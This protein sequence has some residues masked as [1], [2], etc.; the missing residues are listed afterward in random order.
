MSLRNELRAQTR[1][2]TP[3][4]L[5]Q[6]GMMAMGTVDAVMVGRIPGEDAAEIA[7]AAVSLGNMML[8]AG[9]SFAMGVLFGLDPVL[10][11]ALG[12]R[13]PKQFARG[14]QRGFLVGAAL[15]VL[16]AIPL[17]LARPLLSMLDQPVDVVPDASRYAQITVAGLP[18]FLGFT[19]L[20]QT[21]IALGRMRAVIVAVI[22][23][24]G[25]NVLANWALIFG[26]L[27]LPAMG[28][29][30]S[31]W[32][33]TLSRYAMFLGVL[34]LAWP[35]ISERALPL[36][37][38]SLARK[39]I[40][41]F[42]R[43]GLPVGA[44][45]ALEYGAF[46]MVAVM[47]GWIGAREQAGHLVA[48]NLAALSFMVPVGVSSAGTVRVGRAIGAGDHGG[49]RHASW[50]ALLLGVGFMATAAIL[51]VSLPETLTALY[52]PDLDVVQVASALLVIAAA[53]QLFDG[54]QVVTLGLLRGL[55]DTTW[56]AVVN[57]FGYW[58]VGCPLG[59][60]LAFRAGLGA[61]G[62]WWGLVAGLGTVAVI[63]AVRLS[64]LLAS[65]VE[66]VRIES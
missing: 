56:P 52:T 8:F 50:A 28:V 64:R 3:V 43:L 34:Y 10:S 48:L 13:D 32:A 24:N 65:G 4:V 15:T 51:F 53:F 63:L 66:R 60:W 12:A 37:R 7:L 6:L 23:A 11:Q 22:L 42:L 25:V 45:Q 17:L 39:P 55:G 19:V 36:D 41:R 5:A 49:A 33:S 1:L 30:G 21:S 62:L 16:V 26:H 57:L 58:C 38:E 35:E 59:W 47:M 44:Q 31:A 54:T 40:L 20:R 61:S 18:A 9:G 46:A 29:A 2:A 14:V 27:G